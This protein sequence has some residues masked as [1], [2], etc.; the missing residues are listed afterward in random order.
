MVTFQELQKYMQNKL[1][2]GKAQKYI[3]VSGE[4]LEDALK[5][6]SIELGLPVKKLDF[7]VLDPGS[8]GVF[9]VG[10]KPTL[11]LA[12]K[13]SVGGGIEEESFG[14]MSFGEGEDQPVDGRFSLRKDN[15]I[16]LLR[17]SPP[18]NGGLRVTEKQVFE[19][20]ANRF[21]EPFDR[22]LVSKI[23]KK[24]DDEAV[25]IAEYSHSSLENSLI[26]YEVVDLEMKA[27]ILIRPPGP[28]G[29]DPD[30]MAIKEFL[31]ANNIIFGHLDHVIDEISDM[32]V[33]NERILVAEG[34]KPVNG[35]DGRIVYNFETETNKIRLKEI[36]G[37]VDYKE[38]N[39][40]NN[41]VEGQMLAKI[42]APQRGANGHTV[43]GKALPAKDGKP[44]TLEVGNNVKLSDDGT[45]AIA[46]ANG[47][48]MVIGGKIT[49]EPVYTVNGN[50]DL[51]SGNVLFLG[52]V[53]IK[54]NVE[55]G[56]AVKAAG[57]IEI[58][59]SVG[60]CELDAEG[61]IIV[62][63]GIN[64]KATGIIRA[65]GSIWSKF[66]ENTNVEASGHVVVSDGIINSNVNSDKK[67]ICRGKRAS[68]VGGNLRAT[69]IIT[70]KTLGSIAGM[71]TILEVGNDPKTKA[72]HEDLLTRKTT[73][74]KSLEE[75][76]LNIIT[77]EKAKKVKKT[78]PED[79]EKF[80]ATMIR[81]KKE[82][83]ANIEEIN[84]EIK[85][86]E[87]YLSQL[88]S[89]GK[90]SAS[91]KVFPGVKVLIKDAPLEVRNDF[92]AVTF[93]Y[94]NGLVKV[95]RFTETEDEKEFGLEK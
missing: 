38:L 25:V 45:Q 79:K 10:K 44:A 49:V 32:P 47:Q 28:K 50:V 61:D 46:T 5:Q 33:Y 75:I 57:N 24:A 41:V 55:D 22:A 14:D 27:Y 1:E 7:E 36:D 17:V 54:G 4:S 74:E 90:I 12:Y 62:R 48:V 29:A 81:Q 18:E 68:I 91:G 78:L 71:E 51:K 58:H 67:I 39:K 93:V 76:K 83:E 26:T 30:A 31:K 89:N 60:K 64:G 13:S 66:I 21:T 77:L 52:S 37:K 3:N 95:T 15:G 84:D 70:A 73:A 92:K 19:A 69:E 59:G 9:G 94:E 23:V 40:I 85:D 82:V 35:S 11:I 2:E 87:S 53:M 42:V 16:L 6:A 63:Q 34:E 8:K 86:V 43:T 56:F 88:K 80:L 65:G 20:I 72:K